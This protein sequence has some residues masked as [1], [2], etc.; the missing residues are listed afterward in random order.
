[1]TPHELIQRGQRASEII[2]NELWA[3]TFEMLRNEYAIQAQKC[4]AKD[5]LGRFRYI[6]AMRMVETVRN[7]FEAVFIQ[8]K[9]TQDEAAQ[10]Q[11][12]KKGITRFF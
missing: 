11:S 3:E 6:E 12:P 7:H 2:N 4:D 10:F 8:G 9:I 1:M 5:D